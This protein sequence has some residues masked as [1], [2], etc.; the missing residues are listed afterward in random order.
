MVITRSGFVRNRR[1]RIRDKESHLM[2]TAMRQAKGKSG[3]GGRIRDK[4]AEPAGIWAKASNGKNR[5]ASN[6]L[7]PIAA[8][9]LEA[10]LAGRMSTFSP[11]KPRHIHPPLPLF[12]IPHSEWPQVIRRVSQGES[13]R[14][15]FRSYNTSHEAVRRVVLAA[16]HELLGREGDPVALLSEEK[17][18]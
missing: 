1:G 8:P 2:P 3:V 11:Q 5:R 15:I 18:E 17:G 14:Q 4:R 7:S 13:L 16:R 12:K 6:P 10:L 9:P